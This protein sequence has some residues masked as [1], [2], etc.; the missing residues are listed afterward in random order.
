M[1]DFDTKIR[2]FWDTFLA[3]ILALT[4]QIN[5]LSTK[6]TFDGHRLDQLFG[7]PTPLQPFTTIN[8][9]STSSGEVQSTSSGAVPCGNLHLK[10]ILGLP[11]P[12]PTV[13]QLNLPCLC[14]HTGLWHGP[15]ASNNHLKPIFI[16]GTQHQPQAPNQLLTNLPDF[17]S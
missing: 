3:D 10:K 1:E 13:S 7:I 16:L 9:G 6:L 15:W 8:I 11:L 5:S 14:L 17:V 2:L 4:S 12:P